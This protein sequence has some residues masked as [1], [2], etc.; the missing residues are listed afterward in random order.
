MANDVFGIWLIKLNLILLVQ[1]PIPG[2][3][4][5]SLLVRQ[6][7]ECQIRQLITLTIRYLIAMGLIIEHFGVHLL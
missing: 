4:R 3:E 5:V 1:C 2:L 7:Q 6:I